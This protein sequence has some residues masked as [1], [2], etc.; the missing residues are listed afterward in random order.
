MVDFFA[1]ETKQRPARREAERLKTLAESLQKAGQPRGNEMVSGIVV[2]QSPLE[3]L[4]RGLQTAAGGYFAGQ[5]ENK[6]TEDEAALQQRMSEALSKWGSPQEAASILAQ[7]PRTA[8]MAF[9]LMQGETDY[10]RQKELAQM[11]INAIGSGGSTP[12]PM[13]IANQMFELE[14]AMNNPNLPD[15]QRFLAERQYNLLGQA[16]KT[17]G[18]DRGL[19]YGGSMEGYSNVYGQQPPMSVDGN[20]QAPLSVGGNTQDPLAAHA[21]AVAMQQQQTGVSPMQTEELFRPFVAPRIGEVPGYTELMAN[22]AGQIK[23]QE[24]Q[25]QEVGK[26]LGEAQGT[27]TFLEANIPKLEEVTN[28]LGRLSDQATYTYAGRGVDTVRRELGLPSDEGAIARAEY[29]ATVDNEI[30]PLLRDTFGAAFTVKEGETLRATLGDPNKS[31]QEKKAVLNA[32]INQKK[33]Q[34]GA[35]QRQTGQQPTGTQRDQIIQRLRSSGATED[36]INAYLQAR[37]L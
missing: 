10:A 21:Q 15:D 34:V 36:E 28:R 6:A 26:R 17:Y 13:Q 30:L 29:I 8:E 24:A 2:K 1:P 19:G 33:A 32:F 14:Q 31:P 35:L 37:G 3:H 7:D 12:A 18:F 20:M 27:L 16:A 9:K 22:R 23:Q 11:R 25:S 4:A 5:A